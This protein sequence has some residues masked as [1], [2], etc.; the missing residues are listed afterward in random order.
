M[1][2]RVRGRA[3]LAALE[4]GFSRLGDAGG[5]FPQLSGMSVVVDP[6]RPVGRRVIRVAIAGAPLDPDRWYTLA[7]TDSLARGDEGYDA[8]ATAETMIDERA[9]GL[10]AVQIFN[11]IAGLG[12]IAPTIEGRISLR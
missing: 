3:L 2:R 8:L 6:Y 5:R 10:T 7:T 11:R 4:N 1:L 12:V 9:A